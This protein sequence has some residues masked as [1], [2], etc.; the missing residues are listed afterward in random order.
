[1]FHCPAIRKNF[2]LCEKNRPGRLSAG[3]QGIEKMN[4]MSAH[5][6]Y[7]EIYPRLKWLMFFRVLFNTLMLCSTLILHISGSFSPISQP[8]KILYLLII[9]LF[10]VSFIYSVLLT[11][12]RRIILFAY[13]QIAIDTTIVTLIIFL[14]GSF[15]SLFSFLYLVVI[16]YSSIILFK[17]GS[18]TMAALCSI[19]YGIMVDMEYYG[20]IKPFGLDGTL[21]V[22]D[23][24]WSYV[25]YKVMTIMVAC[26]GIAFLGGL[27]AEQYRKTRKELL[28][29]EA[30]VRRVERMAA[31]GEMAAGLAH[32]I[33][34]PLASLS[35]S[36]QLMKEEIEC[37]PAYKKLM[38][39]ILR[40]ADRLSALVNDF[41]L[42]ARPPAG[43]TS[44]IDLGVALAETVALF[45]KDMKIS[46]H[47]TILRKFAPDIW[48]A[49]DA[50]HLQQIFWNLL[51]NAAEAI[52]K[53]KGEIY[54][55]VY[56]T[57]ER[58]A[59]ITIRDNGCGIPPERLST[60]FDPFVTTKSNGTGLGLSVVHRIVASCDGRLDVDSE[61]G[62]GSTF[63]VRLKQV[64]PDR[65]SLQK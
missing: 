15:S 28:A 44:F 14:T 7:N 59:V 2:R 35:G 53:P 54:V 63:K 30:H 56:G 40:E 50:G 26:F 20:I 19:Q 22:T 58:Q 36:I 4:G 42:F 3:I 57:K 43:K 65:I 5:Q 33:K 49:M 39:I 41:L 8:L 17:E 38:Q 47:I 23:Y 64:Q 11:R 1:M 51:L 18:M 32:E 13:I 31:I 52:D 62:K 60:I 21:M 61:P 10:L 27:L 45:E 12:V 46:G 29:M 9:G 48:V 24:A 16:I 25:L 34:N 37:D 55:Q 6:S